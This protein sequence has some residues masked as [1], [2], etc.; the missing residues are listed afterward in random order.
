MGGGNINKEEMKMNNRTATIFI[1]AVLAVLLIGAPAFATGGPGLYELPL[2]SGEIQR[3]L[4]YP[5]RGFCLTAD[6]PP[7]VLAAHQRLQASPPSQ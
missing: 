6:I 4:E 3:L 2:L 7:E 1:C 5:A